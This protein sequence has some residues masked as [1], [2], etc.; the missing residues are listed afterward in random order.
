MEL[1]KLIERQIAAD[2]RRGFDVSADSDEARQLQ[3]TDDLVGL[4]GEVGEFANLLKKVRLTSMHPNYAG[5]S[6]S[7][8]A[9]GLRE[10]LSDATI[11]VFRLMTMLGGD[12][13]AELLAK[14]KENDDRYGP[15]E[16]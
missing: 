7:E 5:P 1:A 9:T 2:K 15:L 16:R 10:E 8:A 4:M 6:L 3:L 14:M 11:Y 13:E 12:F